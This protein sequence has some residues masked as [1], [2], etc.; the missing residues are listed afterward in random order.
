MTPFVSRTSVGLMHSFDWITPHWPAPENVA[1]ISTSRYGGFSR[2]KYSS[3]NLAAHVG[4]EARCVKK[5][6]T[7]LVNELQLSG[8]PTWLNQQHG[9]TAIR[10][11]ASTE[12]NV[13]ADAAYTM[14][15]GIVCAILTAD[16]LPVLL[17]N[18]HGSCVAAVH[19]GW[20]GLL[21]GVLENA[22]NVLPV[23]VSQLICW[24]GPAIGP[25]KFEVGEA[26]RQKFIDRDK[27]HQKAFRPGRPGKYAVD[28]YQISRNI[29]VTH[30]VRAIFGGE[31]CTYTENERFF[32]YRR[33]GVTGRMATMIWLK[34]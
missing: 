32:S 31:H 30:G 3:L 7:L 19:A 34:F 15:T 18:R 24:L 8:E 26:V 23:D 1:C 5:N 14:E 22:L 4:D 27:R 2:G 13:Q 6:R 11:T 12:D 33:D 29:L 28:I 20:R 21:K 17:C 10:L 25:C 16:C 9:N